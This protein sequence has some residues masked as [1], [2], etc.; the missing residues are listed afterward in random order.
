LR[1]PQL[2]KGYHNM[3]AETAVALRTL[4]DGKTWLFTGD[5]VRMDQDGYFYVVDRKKELIKPG[6]FQVWPREVEEVIAIHPA[7]LEAGVAGVPDPDR[8]E[9]V[10]AWVVLRPDA[11][12]S[13]DDI[14]EWCRSRLAPYKVP[15]LV[16][17]RSHLPRSNV[18]KILR[19]ELVREH[20]EAGAAA[21]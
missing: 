3:P 20:R 10:K 2:M 7:V 19:R 21:T 14:V 17:F 11:R 12:A 6:G 8:G 4:Q 16:E 13:A 5:I 9:A 15:T 18:G 1:G